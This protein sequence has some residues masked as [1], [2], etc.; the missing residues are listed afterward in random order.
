MS[1]EPHGVPRGSSRNT[2]A[3]PCLGPLTFPALLY[4][5]PRDVRAGGTRVAQRGR[6][7]LR[8][9]LERREG[10]RR[11][12]SRQ[13][14]P[15]SSPETQPLPSGPSPCHPP[16]R[17]R[18]GPNR[19]PRL[20]AGWSPRQ[21][22]PGLPSN[23]GEGRAA[24]APSDGCAERWMGRAVDGRRGPPGSGR[25]LPPHGIVGKGGRP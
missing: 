18:A 22:R 11:D 23:G 3:V 13:P 4:P 2:A 19:H 20:R 5:T 8:A 9:L 14:S 6:R 25:T 10:A 12:S 21:L 1:K 15:G 17:G 24:D 7:L 16:W